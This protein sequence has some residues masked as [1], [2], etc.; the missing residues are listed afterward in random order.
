MAR[1]DW[2]SPKHEDLLRDRD[3]EN[4]PM[5]REGRQ[6]S[7]K[8]ESV[9]ESSAVLADLMLSDLGVN[10]ASIIT[11]ADSARNIVP[12]NVMALENGRAF[13]QPGTAEYAAAQARRGELNAWENAFVELEHDGA[14]DHKTVLYHGQG[15]RTEMMRRLQQAGPVAEYRRGGGQGGRARGNGRGGGVMGTRGRGNQMGS[16]SHQQHTSQ[17]PGRH[18]DQNN[19]ASN[20]LAA[21]T[22]TSRRA[23]PSNPGYRAGIRGSDSPRGRD[24]RRVS[25]D[26]RVGTSHSYLPVDRTLPLPVEATS[27]P[28]P[29]MRW[30]GTVEDQVRP[31]VR[32]PPRPRTGQ[33][34]LAKPSDFMSAMTRLRAAYSAATA[35]GTTEV[36][37]RTTD[38]DQ[39]KTVEP[40]IIFSPEID[41]APYGVR[42]LTPPPAAV[43]S[44]GSISL[45]SYSDDLIG[46]EIPA[47]RNARAEEEE[48]TEAEAKER[49][50]AEAK[51]DSFLASSNPSDDDMG[52]KMERSRQGSEK[53]NF[54]T[55]EEARPSP[56]EQALPTTKTATELL[57]A[58]ALLGAL[59]KLSE[60]SP[61]PSVVTAIAD[62]EATIGNFHENQATTLARSG[63]GF[64]SSAD[65]LPA[66]TQ[67]GDA[68]HTKARS[69]DDTQGSGKQV[70]SSRK[71]SSNSAASH[72][73]NA[74]SSHRSFTLARNGSLSSHVQRLQDQ[75]ANDVMA[76]LKDVL[77]ITMGNLTQ[78]LHHDPSGAYQGRASYRIRLPTTNLGEYLL[79]VGHRSEQTTTLSPLR[80]P[81]TQ[82]EAARNI[83]SANHVPTPRPQAPRV[84]ESLDDD[85]F[86]R[87]LRNINSTDHRPQNPQ[88]MG[89][90][91]PDTLASRPQDAT[92]FQSSVGNTAIAGPANP[93][94]Q[95]S[96]A[97]AI[98]P[99]QR[100]ED[101]NTRLPIAT[102]A[103]MTV[104]PEV[105]RIHTVDA[106]RSGILPTIAPVNP[107]RQPTSASLRPSA[108]SHFNFSIG[109]SAALPPP[110]ADK[111]S[112]TATPTLTPSTQNIPRTAAATHATDNALK[113][114]MST[115]SSALNTVPSRVIP[116]S[117]TNALGGGVSASRWS[118]ASSSMPSALVAAS[119]TAA[120]FSM[121]TTL[122]GGDNLLPNSGNPQILEDGASGSPWVSTF[123]DPAIGDTTAL[124]STY[125][126]PS[127]HQTQNVPGF[128]IQA[129][130]LQNDPGAA[131]RAQYASHNSVLSNIQ[132]NQSLNSSAVDSSLV[133]SA[134]TKVSTRRSKDPW[135]PA[136]RRRL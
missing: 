121:A 99:A 13:R 17:H 29:H 126:R 33:V 73:S 133:E 24:N 54:R 28:M 112:S 83:G 98:V 44:Q 123:V 77:P 57:E 79:P 41:A 113:T 51:Y 19:I 104:L 11:A 27:N 52:S 69:G 36:P 89:Y 114:A 26:V 130:I 49:T 84:A 12:V 2:N 75:W 32:L 50:E 61:L 7:Q 3:R 15:H 85:S 86:T 37:V 127:S 34:N 53:N 59:R 92:I 129:Q 21:P 47:G 108:P 81:L 72:P 58:R 16:S 30:V 10:R 1:G 117:T 111:V 48:R 8:P 96:S 115:A 46:L 25:G 4:T 67:V 66:N 42:V 18:A 65:G 136:R 20:T 106:V 5:R 74:A 88:V 62:L 6:G 68:V 103:S 56:S 94:R 101:I 119:S 40:E 110:S 118:T 107:F 76:S 22:A 23:A 35:S 45:G 31:T 134:G 128:I 70:D 131:A 93:F 60:L 82:D 39:K 9:E 55:S 91:F 125:Q 78:S 95:R 135:D 102:S 132:E 87:T 64:S 71:S 63:A 124:F 14:D 105:G 120:P 38:S 90:G 43:P 100:T 80:P 122:G 109:S 116:L 97:A